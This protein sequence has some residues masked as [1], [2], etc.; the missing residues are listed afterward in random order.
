MFGQV[1]HAHPAFTEH[2]EQPIGGDALE[3]QS[4]GRRC[5]L[6]RCVAEHSRRTR[7]FAHLVALLL[8]ELRVRR[9]QSLHIDGLASHDL[10]DHTIIEFIVLFVEI[11]GVHAL[12]V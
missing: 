11:S 7:Q 5:H 9:E 12:A 2:R 10:I 6:Q 8:A 3:G 1:D 4:R